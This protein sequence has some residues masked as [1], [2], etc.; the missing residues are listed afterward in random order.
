MVQRNFRD[1][2]SGVFAVPPPP[3][4]A[5]GPPWCCRLRDTKRPPATRARGGGLLSKPSCQRS[6]AP[7]RMRMG[8]ARIYG[9]KRLPAALSDPKLPV[10][11]QLPCG[12]ESRDGGGLPVPWHSR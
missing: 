7:R 12:A 9:G 2:R 3:A 4:Y 11:V 10:T 1:W 5:R 6:L 8:L